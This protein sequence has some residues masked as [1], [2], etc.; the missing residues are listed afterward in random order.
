MER[1]QAAPGLLDCSHFE[2]AISEQRSQFITAET[3]EFFRGLIS[4][5]RDLPLAEAT[6]YLDNLGDLIEY[7]PG[8]ADELRYIRETVEGE[9]M[10]GRSPALKALAK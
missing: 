8:F 3:A 1:V 6:T 2:K 10:L 5:A 4:R 9:F 7:H